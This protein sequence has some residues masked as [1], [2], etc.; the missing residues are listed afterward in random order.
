MFYTQTVNFASAEIL[1]GQPYRSPNA[2]VWSLGVLLSVLLTGETPF[3]N[4]DAA[5]QGKQCRDTHG[6]KADHNT[7]A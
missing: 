5:V 3:S 2:E 1:L 6:N 4:A 7:Q